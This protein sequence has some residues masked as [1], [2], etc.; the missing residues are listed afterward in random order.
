MIFCPACKCGH[1]FRVGRV[2]GPSWT[3]NGNMEKPTF[4]PSLLCTWKS[5]DPPIPHVCHS[6]VRDGQIQFLNDCTHAMAGQ[7]VALEPF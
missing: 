5:G 4:A 3:F 6:Y 2:G 1:G 7:T